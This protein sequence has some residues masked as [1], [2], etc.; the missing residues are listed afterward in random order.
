M[1]SSSKTWYILM[2]WGYNMC[3][4]VLYESYNNFLI[5]TQLG[6][7]T[8]FFR[9]FFYFSCRAPPLFWIKSG[10]EFVPTDGDVCYLVVILRILEYMYGCC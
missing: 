5:S 8:V 10:G 1:Y 9:Y 6:V 7:R 2:I 4:C 3:M